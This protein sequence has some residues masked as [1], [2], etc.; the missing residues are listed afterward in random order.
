MRGRF[1]INCPSVFLKI[2]KLPEWNEDNFKTFKN[3]EGYLSQ[4]SLERNMWLLVNHTNQQTLCI[5]TKLLPAITNKR[6]GNYKTAGSYKII[7]LTV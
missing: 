2:L 4:R 7:A 3:H 1:G 6:A 5:E